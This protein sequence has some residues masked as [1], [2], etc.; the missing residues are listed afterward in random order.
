MA[1]AKVEAATSKRSKISKAQQLT[2]LEVLIA[3]LVFGACA[4]LS[5]F[6]IKYINFNTKIISAKSQAIT[7]Y[8]QSLRNVGVCVDTDKNGRLSNEEL[9]N[10]NS[11]EVSLNSV[12]NSLRYKVLMQMAQNTDLES[13]AR[14][15]NEKCYD[16]KGEKIDFNEKYEKTTDELEKQQYL[17]MSKVCSALRV[18]PDA[19]PAQKNTEA[20][21]ASLNQVLLL[22]GWEPERLT[23]RDDAVESRIEGI[24]VIPVTLQVEG[25]SD[26]VLRALDKIEHSVREFDITSGTIEWTNSGLSLNALAD[27]YYLEDAAEI[28]KTV[29][30]KASDKTR[31]K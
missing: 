27:A 31:R 10:C 15:R 3:S 21:M 20:L 1:E 6:L 26:V 14:Q 13:V 29:V 7:D 18:I 19:L 22:T 23:P 17:Q 11:N 30:I 2:M 28:E 16:D 12:T 5:I 25:G 24:G 9:E 4:V 8:D